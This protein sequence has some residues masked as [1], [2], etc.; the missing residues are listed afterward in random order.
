[1]QLQIREN[2]THPNPFHDGSHEEKVRL[3]VNCVNCDHQFDRNLLLSLSK[4]EKWFRCLAKADQRAI[5]DR[6]GYKY[7]IVGPNNTPYVR[8]KSGNMAYLV[9]LECPTCKTITLASVDFYEMQPAR[10][11]ATL[12]ALAEVS[13]A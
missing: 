1:M 6:L 9:N 4:G 7:E 2:R 10:Y 13:Q 5:A 8:F 11:I 3:K 12:N